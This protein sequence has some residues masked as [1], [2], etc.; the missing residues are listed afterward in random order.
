MDSD[1]QPDP[2]PTTVPAPESPA[3]AEAPGS[4]TTPER[5][6]ARDDQLGG[7]ATPAFGA[8]NYGS[9]ASA[10]PEVDA[11]SRSARDVAPT[12]DPHPYAAPAA[13]ARSA[14]GLPPGTDPMRLPLRNATPSDAVRRFFAKYAVFTGRASRSEFWWVQLAFGIFYGALALITAGLLLASG[15]GVGGGTG[16]AAVILVAVVGLLS[17]AVLVP[18]IALFWRRM[19]DAGLSGLFTL[20]LLV[21]YLGVIAGAVLAA[22]RE[23]P[24]GRRFDV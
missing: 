20:L 23:N 6:E 10:A 12:S 9:A 7:F 16:H 4:S 17:L 15:T 18:Q 8:A 21:P 3:E 22:Q 11:S 5:T 24:E 14:P 1:D 19:H 2:D 13:D